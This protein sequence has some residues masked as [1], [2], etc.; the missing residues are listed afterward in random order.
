MSDEPVRP[1]VM[2][3]VDDV[4]DAAYIQ[5]TPGK[6]NSTRHVTADVLVDLGEHDVVIGVEVLRR[7]AEIPFDR[8]TSEF[9][10]HSAVI[11]LLKTIQPS[12]AAFTVTQGHDGYADPKQTTGSGQLL[13]A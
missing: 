9:H 8:L 4:A 2:L 1:I 12:V 3:M 11:D 6:V 13:T 10:V 7:T 5:L